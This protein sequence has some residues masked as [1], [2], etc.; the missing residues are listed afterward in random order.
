M[1]IMD[2]RYLF[3]CGCP[4]SGTTAL[5]K[6]FN[7]HPD[8]LLGMERYA[9]LFRRTPHAMKRELFTVERFLDIREGDCGYKSFDQRVAYSNSPMG[10]I[11]Q[12]EIRTASVVGDKITQLYKNFDVFEGAEW[13]GA[14]V[15]IVQI[16][17]NIFNVARSYE[18]RL[19]DPKDTWRFNYMDGIKEWTDAIS[20][21]LQAAEAKG[22]RTRFLVV[23]Y[24]NLF[25]RGKD[26]F[27]I[28]CRK[29]IRAVGLDTSR[30]FEIDV[31]RVFLQGEKVAKRREDRTETVSS[32]EI[33]SHVFPQ[34][35]E[36][37]RRLSEQTFV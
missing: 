1:Q 33:A 37:Y 2:N 30:K 3:V 11:R 10:N 8:V 27:L 26:Q 18:A 9:I 31:S 28:G 32:D 5:T 22:S 14:E 23:G 19:K 29:L 17:R 6:V 25:E 36:T 16:I 7:W 35:L 4:R 12:E 21:G 13:E 24:E 20:Y 15:T 34:A